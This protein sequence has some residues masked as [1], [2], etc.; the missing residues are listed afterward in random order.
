MLRHPFIQSNARK[1]RMFLSTVALSR[2]SSL[3]PGKGLVL[4]L[5][6]TL[7]FMLLYQVS[8]VPIVRSK[9]FHDS[10]GKS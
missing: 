10:V 1:S 9:M 5:T 3:L 4:L 6:K 7:K 2:L 8:I